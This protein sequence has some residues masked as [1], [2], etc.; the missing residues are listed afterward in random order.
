ME[1]VFS[2]CRN[3][4]QTYAQLFFV[5]FICG[6]CKS[7]SVSIIFSLIGDLLDAED[8]DVASSRLSVMTGVVILFGQVYLRYVGDSK[9]WKQPFMLSG[10][11]SIITSLMVLQ[12]C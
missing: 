2:W 3:M 4:S 7:G 10:T 11:L 12:S 6:D 1:Y 9:E 8:R 5:R